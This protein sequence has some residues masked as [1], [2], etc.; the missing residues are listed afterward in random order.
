MKLCDTWT[1]FRI[2]LRG[3]GSGKGEV[4]SETQLAICCLKLFS[5]HVE[6]HCTFCFSYVPKIFHS[7]FNF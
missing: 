2:I 1:C 5:D 4:K 3:E 6:A 7:K